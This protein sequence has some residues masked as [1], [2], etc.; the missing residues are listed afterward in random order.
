M[1]EIHAERCPEL[2]NGRGCGLLL[3]RSKLQLLQTLGRIDHRVAGGGELAHHRKRGLGVAAHELARLTIGLQKPLRA[4]DLSYGV[5]A[6]AA[7]RAQ[8]QA[9]AGTTNPLTH[10]A[11]AEHPIAGTALAPGDLVGDERGDK[12]KDEGGRRKAEDRGTNMHGLT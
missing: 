7:P 10:A 12:T 5:G 9:E 1:R 2:G 3:T 11:A 4:G 8:I 6:R